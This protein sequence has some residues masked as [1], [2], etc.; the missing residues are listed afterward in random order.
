V[1]RQLLCAEFVEGQPRLL[2]YTPPPRQAAPI[3][4]VPE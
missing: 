4:L 3:P 2:G 1:H